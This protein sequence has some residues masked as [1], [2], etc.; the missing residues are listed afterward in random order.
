MDEVIKPTPIEVDQ[1]RLQR[2]IEANLGALTVQC[3]IKDAIIEQ[4]K[5]ENQKLKDV[6]A[7]GIPLTN[8]RPDSGQMQ[9]KE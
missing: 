6:L 2:N 8:H 4:L 5:E 1:Q 9:V 7:R 3:C